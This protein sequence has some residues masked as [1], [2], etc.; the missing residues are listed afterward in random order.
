MVHIASAQEL[1]GGEN[2]MQARVVSAGFLDDAEPGP[3]L[4]RTRTN[5]LED[6]RKGCILGG[7]SVVGEEPMS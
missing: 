6:Q 4:C 5:G 1:R 2:L 3:D 7:L